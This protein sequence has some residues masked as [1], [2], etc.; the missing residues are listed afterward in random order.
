MAANVRVLGALGVMGVIQLGYLAWAVSAAENTWSLLAGGFV[1][2]LVA[3]GVAL[4]MLSKGFREDDGVSDFLLDV[5][6]G[7]K[8]LDQ[9]LD[10]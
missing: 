5:V 6:S 1:V 3:S 9:R 10:E 4:G 8:R 7:K 2:L